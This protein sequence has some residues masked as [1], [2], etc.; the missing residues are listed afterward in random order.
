[1]S[2]DGYIADV[3]GGVNWLEGQ[4]NDENIDVYSEFVKDIDTVLMGWNTYHQVVTELSPNEWVYK[5]FMT[6]VF[7]HRNEKSSE[8]INFTS[9]NPIALLNRLKEGDGK[10]IWICEG[11]SL[12]GQLVKE[13]AIDE[14]YISVIPTILGD[15]VRLFEKT[16]SEIKLRLCD[17]QTYNGITHLVYVR[18]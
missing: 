4:G 10:N 5:D 3:N 15:G 8:K 12:V 14:Y 17:F 11:A 6:Y 7:T 18:R 1:M 2:L 16:D 9:E 13:D